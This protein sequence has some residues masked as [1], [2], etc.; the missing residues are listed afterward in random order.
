VVRSW[1]VLS[2][3]QARGVQ[4]APAPGVATPSTASIAAATTRRVMVAPFPSDRFLRQAPGHV[5]DGDRGRACAP[6]GRRG[7]RSS[8]DADL[9]GPVRIDPMQRR[10]LLLLALALIALGPTPGSGQVL[11]SEKRRLAHRRLRARLRRRRAAKK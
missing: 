6:L 10:E 8:L 2:F 5:N 9:A 11:G 1:S 4:S 7:R 3:A